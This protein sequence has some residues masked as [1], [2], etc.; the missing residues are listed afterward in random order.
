MSRLAPRSSVLPGSVLLGPKLLGQ[1]LLCLGLLAAPA[2]RTDQA[3]RSVLTVHAPKPIGP[4]S[5]A[6]A[7]GDFLFLSGQIGLDPESGALV[8]GGIVP[9]TERA[10]ENL[11]A[12]LAAEGLD[13][14][15]VVSVNAYLVDLEEF[16][17]FNDAYG[18]ALGGEAPARATVQVAALPKGARVELQ[19]IALRP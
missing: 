15:H 3:P 17:A 19:C 4:Y 9:E 1:V 11:R 6:V 2:C 5:Q 14:R 10:L 13:F 8:S 7:R 18:K 16:A 12:V